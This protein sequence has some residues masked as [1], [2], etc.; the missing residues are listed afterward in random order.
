MRKGEDAGKEGG[1]GKDGL[2][3]GGKERMEGSSGRNEERE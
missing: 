3:K 2:R 1:K